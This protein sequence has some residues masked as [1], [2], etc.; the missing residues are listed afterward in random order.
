[1]YARGAF[2]EFRDLQSQLQSFQSVR[3][4][5]GADGRGKDIYKKV[6]FVVK[7]VHFIICLAIVASRAV[8]WIVHHS[9]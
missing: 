8:L 6:R 4:S 1:M 2:N 9:F 3:A 5:F 7:I